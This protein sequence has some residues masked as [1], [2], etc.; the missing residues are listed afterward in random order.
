MTTEVAESASRM[1]Q[2]TR[3]HDHVRKP[4]VALH[5]LLTPIASDQHTERVSSYYATCLSHSSEF[6]RAK[7]TSIP[8]TS[9]ELPQ[10]AHICAFQ[11]L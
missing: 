6:W 2:A 5:Q 10:A 4:F 7:G 9:T 1:A 8:F 3:S 11:I